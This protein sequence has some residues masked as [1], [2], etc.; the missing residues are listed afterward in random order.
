[1][2][3][4]HQAEIIINAGVVRANV[5]LIVGSRD[6]QVIEPNQQAAA[7]LETVHRIAIVEGATHLFEEPGALEEG[8]RLARDWFARRLPREALA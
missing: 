2:N 6:E 8:Q 4:A 1:M 5:L 3:A 7:R